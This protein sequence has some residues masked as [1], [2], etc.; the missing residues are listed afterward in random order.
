MLERRIDRYSALGLG[1]IIFGVPLA[2]FSYL[3]LLSVSFTALGLACVILGATVLFTPTS[4]V[5]IATIRAMVEG[6]CVNI[7]ALLEEFDARERAVYLPPKDGRVFTYVPLV[8]NP[9]VSAAWAAM[10][11]P[12]RVVT[13]VKGE[14]SLMVFSPGSEVVRLSLLTSEAGVEE[15]LSHV[16]VD[17]LE[18]VESVKAIKDMGRVVVDMEISRVETEFPRY[19]MVLGSLPTSIAGCVLSTVLDVPMELV[20]EQYEKRRIRA[21][22]G[23]VPR[24]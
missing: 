12:V 13:R 1:L 6:S 3:V 2:V 18:A 8:S 23:E 24:G 4:P 21:V 20:D 14:P 11:A 9:G 10:E 16:L 17:F 7:E 19:R 15:A 22:F 5:P